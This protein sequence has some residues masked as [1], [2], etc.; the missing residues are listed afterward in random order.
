MSIENSDFIVESDHEL[1][2][3]IKNK[4][5]LLKTD[6]YILFRYEQIIK[7]LEQSDENQ[8]YRL[9]NVDIIKTLRISPNNIKNIYFQR[10]IIKM[11][12]ENS[13]ENI[14]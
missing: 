12:K 14:L 1:L 6:V 5:S 2:I 3:K 9:S 4:P 8:Y 10:R 11:F 7:L 13:M